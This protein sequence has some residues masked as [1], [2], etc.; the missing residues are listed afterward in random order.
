MID[1][2]FKP[3]TATVVEYK[4]PIPTLEQVREARKSNPNI[5]A[6]QLFSADY[7]AKLK[8]PKAKFPSEIIVQM[9]GDED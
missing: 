4:E 1:N 9:R 5:K 6:E 2:K 7:L 3:N 8:D